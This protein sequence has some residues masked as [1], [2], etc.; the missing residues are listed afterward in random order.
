MGVPP[1]L[2]MAQQSHFN[3]HKS[4]RYNKQPLCVYYSSTAVAGVPDSKLGTAR[5]QV[6][7]KA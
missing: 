3:L 2:L 1:D 6:K 7:G 4:M 5:G